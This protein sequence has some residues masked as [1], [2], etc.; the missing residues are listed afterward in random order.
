MIQELISQLQSTGSGL[1]TVLTGQWFLMGVGS[2]I[3]SLVVRV[4]QGPVRGQEMAGF[5]L[6]PILCGIMIIAIGQTLFM[7]PAPGN[8]WMF[9]WNWSIDQLLLLFA[10]L[11]WALGLILD[12]IRR[13]FALALLFGIALGIGQCVALVM[14][15]Q[16][17]GASLPEMFSKFVAFAVVSTFITWRYAQSEN[18]YSV[19]RISQMALA[20]LGLLAVGL[21]VDW[22]ALDRVLNGVFTVVLLPAFIV[23]WLMWTSVGRGSNL[24]AVGLFGGLGP[25]LLLLGYQTLVTENLSITAASLLVIIMVGPD[26]VSGFERRRSLPDRVPFMSGLLY[27]MLIFILYI[28]LVFTAGLDARS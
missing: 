20:A 1:L 2:L 7:E 6:A 4:L 28:A 26:L 14:M 21:I 18:G 17:E 3:F 15:L 9:S 22:G 27:L 19:L 11:G 13:P 24:G 25:L 16:A 23:G 8:T 10:V 5:A 12:V